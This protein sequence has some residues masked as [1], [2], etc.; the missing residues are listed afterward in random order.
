VTYYN[1]ALFAL[2]LG[3]LYCWRE[4]QASK[5]RE[6]ALL[7]R[8]DK[9]SK[10]KRTL[11]AVPGHLN[12]HFLFNALNTIRYFV[13]TNPASARG[14]LLDLSLVLQS[15]L[16]KDGQV[17]LRDELESG[18][19]Y[20]R[21]EGA[22]LGPRLEIVDTI[23]ESDLDQLIETHILSHL[24]ES[25]VKGVA[26]RPNGGV[27]HLDFRNRRLILEADGHASLPSE[28]VKT[29]GPNLQIAREETTRFEWSLEQT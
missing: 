4:L 29:L 14:L 15:A 27:I 5:L 16:R 11:P 7:E 17:S 21:L 25:L 20:L 24:L 22:R 2:A 23:S 1:L 9:L 19:G 26:E 28:V 8:L 3:G 10:E 6:G 13:R 12:P 18:R